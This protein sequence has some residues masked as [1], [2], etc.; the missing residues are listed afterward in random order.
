MQEVTDSSSVVPTIEPCISCRRFR[1]NAPICG[2]SVFFGVHEFSRAKARQ[3]SVRKRQHRRGTRKRCSVSFSLC[4]DKGLTIIASPHSLCLGGARKTPPRSR[5]LTAMSKTSVQ[6][7]RTA[8]RADAHNALFTPVSRG[9]GKL[10][11]A[12]QKRGFACGVIDSALFLPSLKKT[13][14]TLQ[15]LSSFPARKGKLRKFPKIGVKI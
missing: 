4:G 6:S 2:V 13:R 7:A 5:F 3:N 15:P 14:R 11:A 12:A 9:V 10:S 1:P 8:H